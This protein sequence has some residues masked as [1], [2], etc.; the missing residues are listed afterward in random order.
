M[1]WA[2][3]LLRVTLGSQPGDFA[4]A[5]EPLISIGFAR[6]ALDVANFSPGTMGL[7]LP[8]AFGDSLAGKGNAGRFFHPAN[9][10]KSPS[11]F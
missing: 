3:R 10:P 4:L 2:R 1:V 11:D 6:E 8:I 9:M 7:D 5:R